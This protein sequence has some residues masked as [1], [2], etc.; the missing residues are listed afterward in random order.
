[1]FNIKK[2]KSFGHKLV[3]EEVFN[4]FWGNPDEPVKIDIFG[5]AYIFADKVKLDFDNQKILVYKKDE[6]IGSFPVSGWGN[7][8]KLMKR[9][10]K[11]GIKRFR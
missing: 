2:I 9:G 8:D 10:G 1:M 3:T 7:L 6:E 11:T 5:G 4:E